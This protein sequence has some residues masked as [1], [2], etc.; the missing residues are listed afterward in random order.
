M[1]ALGSL[2]GKGRKA[3]DPERVH[4]GLRSYLKRE[5]NPERVWEAIQRALEGENESARVSASKLLL[6]ALYEPSSDTCP[7]CAEREVNAE[8]VEAKLLDLLARHAAGNETDRKQ[9]I[10]TAVHE[11]L[12]P[13]AEH[14]D[15]AQVE[16]QLV[17]RL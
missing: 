16:E 2:G 14:V 9:Q 10:R 5:A 6:D 12:A 4:E 3:I 17:A 8:Q 1:R 11:E 15:V 7:V 13:L